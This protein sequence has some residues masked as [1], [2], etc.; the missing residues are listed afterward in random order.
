MQARSVEQ[1]RE[2]EGRNGARP[3]SGAIGVVSGASGVVWLT[4]AYLVWRASTL[5]WGTILLL[6]LPL[7]AVEIWGLLQ[8]IALRHQAV[9]PR[10]PASLSTSLHGHEPVDVVITTAGRSPEEMERTLIACRSLP[11]ERSIRIVDRWLLPEIASLAARHGADY[12]T[13]GVD[14][15]DDPSVVVSGDDERLVLWL[16]AGQVPMPDVDDA[17]IW[18]DDPRVAVVQIGVGL[19]NTDSLAHIDRG[20]DEHALD[21]TVLGPALA[22][23]GR[24]PWFG[25]AAILRPEPV[26]AVARAEGA[27]S[28]RSVERALIRL[29]ADG[30]RTAF[31]ARPLV[32]DAAPDSLAE[33][34]DD[35]RT[36]VRRTLGVLRTADSPLTGSAIPLA[37]RWTHLAMW[38]RFADGLRLATLVAITAVVLLTGVMP[39]TAPLLLLVPCWIV[40]MLGAA[41]ARHRMAA[42]TMAYGD[43]L[44][45]G[46]RTLGVDLAAIGDVLTGRRRRQA[47]DDDRAQGWASLG[48]LRLLTL[49]VVGLELAV[50]ARGATLVWGDALPAFPAGARMVVLVFALG[51]LIPMIDV[52]QLMVT[53]RQRRK[54]TRIRTVVPAT[55][56]GVATSTLDLAAN[57]I[58][59]TLAD[60]PSLGRDRRRPARTPPPGRRHLDRLGRG[61]RALDHAARDRRASRGRRDRPHVGAL[62]CRSDLVLRR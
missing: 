19:L 7:F 27:G 20:R 44:R 13:V 48:R 3:R 61:P 10:P 37:V 24:A 42:G 2:G 39:T 57:G 14:P 12:V 9:H 23:R 60:P 36:R 56:D 6:S 31:D 55:V 32:R 43:W 11:G 22:A 21:R 5:G 38:S 28:A 40:T 26:R 53:R 25:A 52:L 46:W 50:V 1:R 58:G 18:F 34:L 29:H 49:A 4:V 41:R 33:Y 16:E 30:R 59:F 51:A 8:L 45:N 47:L 54:T 17:T 62:P 35:R 15:M